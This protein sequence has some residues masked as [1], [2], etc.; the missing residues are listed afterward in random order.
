[1]S[2][3]SNKE[4]KGFTKIQNEFVDCYLSYFDPSTSKIY[5][6]LKSHI[7]GKRKSC[8]VSEKLLAKKSGLNI[9]SVNRHINALERANVL[10]V[11]RRPGYTNIY[12][13]KSFSMWKPELLTPVSYPPDTHDEP[14]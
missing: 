3:L 4:R 8:Y 2:E 14:S 6:C 1:M 5:L 13:F 10:E 7:Y 12:S 9:R 11:T